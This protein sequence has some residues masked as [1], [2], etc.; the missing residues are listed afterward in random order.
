MSI[1][2]MSEVWRT[3]L[4]T[5]E[6]MVLLVIADHA[7]DDGDNAWP[8]QATIAERASCTIRT[9]QRCV[10]NLVRDGY[11]RMEKGAGGSATCRD[12]RR[13][14]RYA[15]NLAKL[16]GDN[17]STRKA[18]R[19]DIEVS[20]GATLT[21]DTGRH[22]RP[23]NHPSKPSLETP[24]K[25]EEF[26][27]AYP[28]KVGK[29]SALK[30]WTQAIKDAKPETIITGAIAYAKDPTRKEPYTAHPATWLN[31]GRWMDDMV[32]P[33]PV[34]SLPKYDSAEES[35]RRANAVPMPDEVKKMLAN[36][37]RKPYD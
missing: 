4:P 28:K 11:V 24:M 5:S 3:K 30:A 13:P 18:L 37:T 36:I 26:W 29:K 31:A 10:N 14:H 23:M 21:T 9:V 34:P 27:N 8:S 35:R 16:R 32:A 15:I 25:F 12:D 6:K 33:K 20:N 22:L 17:L 1:R 19:G 2:V 7:S